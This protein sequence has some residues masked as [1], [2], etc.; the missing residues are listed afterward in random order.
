M[1]KKKVHIIWSLDDSIFE[2][3]RAVEEDRVEQMN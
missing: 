2:A 3:Y 1:K